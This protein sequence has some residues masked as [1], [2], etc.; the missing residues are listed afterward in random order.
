M[1]KILLLNLLLCFSLSSINAQSIKPNENEFSFASFQK[2]KGV[3]KIVEYLGKKHVKIQEFDRIGFLIEENNLY[4]GFY[5]RRSSKKRMTNTVVGD[6]ILIIKENRLRD[7][8]ESIASYYFS[9]ET[10]DCVRYERFSGSSAGRNF[11][12]EDGLLKSYIYYYYGRDTVASAVKYTYNERKQL[13]KEERK[14]INEL[15]YYE[16]DSDGYLHHITVIRPNTG[17][18][19]PVNTHVGIP[20][21]SYAEPNRYEIEYTD[22]DKRGNWTKSYYETYKGLIFRSKRKII[23]YE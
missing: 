11:V 16:Y 23:Y 19:D 20:T 17:P 12:Y 10:L 1:K 22:F 15:I 9:S 5:S 14:S 13:M 8:K 21:Y 6:S 7:Q 18:H 4:G 3:K 2:N